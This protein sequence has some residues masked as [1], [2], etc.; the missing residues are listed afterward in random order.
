MA[1]VLGV[2][3]LATDERYATAKGRSERRE[4]LIATIEPLFLAHTT[5]EW[6]ERFDA[7]RIPCS[8]VQ[9]V[10]QALAHPQVAAMD[11]LHEVDDGRGGTVTLCGVPLNMSATPPQPGRRPPDLG[12][13]SE[14]VLVE[15]GYTNE[16]I[17]S[18]RN[19]GVL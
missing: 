13:H 11:M 10:G 18:M 5:A 1:A 7:E 4:A 9:D 2:P 19:E 3:E 14:E 15:L 17:A 6:I 12:E 16:E 8:A